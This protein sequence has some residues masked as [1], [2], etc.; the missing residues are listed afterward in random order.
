M[1]V[2]LMHRC[3]PLLSPG[4]NMLLVGV[5]GPQIP[6]EEVLVKHMGSLQY[7]VSY[8]LKERGSYILVV[9]WGEDHIPGSPFQVTVP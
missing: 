3:L 6:C 8:L 2:L 9:K 7:N 4:K 1:L 5:H